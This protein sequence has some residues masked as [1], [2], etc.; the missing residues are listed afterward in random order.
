MHSANFGDGASRIPR[1][2]VALEDQKC[3]R[4]S[5]GACRAV[6]MVAPFLDEVEDKDT[7]S[8]SERTCY[9]RALGHEVFG[10]DLIRVQ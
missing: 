5:P 4:I 9:T 7:T 8:K 10:K 6:E 3:S 1:S 2:S